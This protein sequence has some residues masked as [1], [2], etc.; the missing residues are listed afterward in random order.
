MSAMQSFGF[1]Q[2]WQNLTGSRTSGVT[3]YNTT[4]KPIQVS[5]WDN[6]SGNLSG[7]QTIEITV[8]GVR[9]AYTKMYLATEAST[10]FC[11]AVVPPGA[12]YIVTISGVYNQLVVTELR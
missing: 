1:G 10:V 9:A 5:A 11:S 8:N 2:T 4:G 3:Y 6:V 7:Y 12:S